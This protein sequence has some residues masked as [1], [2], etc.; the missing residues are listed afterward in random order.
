MNEEESDGAALVGDGEA[1]P[2]ERV[3]DAV[4]VTE[5]VAETE[6]VLEFVGV[7][8]MEPVR[9]TEMVED[10]VEPKDVDAVGETDGAI[11]AEGV[12]EGPHTPPLGG[13]PASDDALVKVSARDEKNR[14]PVCV[15]LRRLMV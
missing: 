11:V 15:A 4:G 14:A 9:E 5:G 8:E 7:R 3:G 6:T 10:A 13:T 2:G 12:A 1:V